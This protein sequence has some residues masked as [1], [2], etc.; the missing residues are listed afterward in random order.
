MY[1][2]TLYI[3]ILKYEVWWYIWDMLY[4]HISCMYILAVCIYLLYVCDCILLHGLRVKSLCWMVIYEN[5]G[6]DITLSSLCKVKLSCFVDL[7]ILAYLGNLGQPLNVLQRI[8]FGWEF[9]I[10][11]MWLYEH[12]I[13]LIV[14][15]RYL[16]FTFCQT[17]Y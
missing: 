10:I 6:T 1:G 17:V 12:I 16:T 8:L 7:V 5:M 4:A 9:G 3:S 15:S 14:S 2:T 11:S 13:L